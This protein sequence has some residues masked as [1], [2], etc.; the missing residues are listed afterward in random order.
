MNSIYHIWQHLLWNASGRPQTFKIDPRSKKTRFE[1]YSSALSGSGYARSG[2][3]VASRQ[4]N[5]Y[6]RTVPLSQS[7]IAFQVKLFLFLRTGFPS[8]LNYIS[9]N[10]G[11]Q[12]YISESLLARN[13]KCFAPDHLDPDTVLVQFL[14]F[15]PTAVQKR[16]DVYFCSS[17]GQDDTVHSRKLSR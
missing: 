11:A 3:L 16:E 14:F 8:K 15:N 4:R 17:I 13:G 6:Q 7:P 5:G 1:R 12:K 10:Q 9:S 2:S